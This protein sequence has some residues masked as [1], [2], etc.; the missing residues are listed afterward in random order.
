MDWEADKCS[1]SDPLSQN[2]ASGFCNLRKQKA[3]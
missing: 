2:L 1:D 3:N